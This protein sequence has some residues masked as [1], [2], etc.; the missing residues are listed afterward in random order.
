VNA[1]HEAL[2]AQYLRLPEVLESAAAG[3][4][5]T[6]YDWSTGTGWSI[7]SYIHH[8]VEGE[9]LWQVILRSILGRDGAEIPLGWYFEHEQEQWGRLWQ[10]A[11]RPVEPTLA[12]F[13][14]S[15][16]VMAELLSRLPDEAW[17]QTGRVAF[18]GNGQENRFKAQDIIRMH[19]LHVEGH[20]RDIGA[21][22][23]LHGRS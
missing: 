10:Y 15:T 13:R 9:L 8:T 2:L 11:S 5:E 14:A 18:P 22:R 20:A 7:R 19:I 23:K 4:A 3:L 6:E 1:E 12:L 16:R 17:E 21:I